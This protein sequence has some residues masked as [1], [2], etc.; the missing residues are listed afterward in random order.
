[1]SLNIITDA[2]IPVVLT[3]GTRGTIAPWQ[4]ADQAVL[5]PDWPRAD[6][7]IACLELLIGLVFLADPP[8]HEEDWQDRQAPDPDRLRAA[9][10]PFA[11]AFELLGDGPRFMQDLEPLAGEASPPD[12]L[13]IDSAGAN[14][15]RNNADLLVHRNRYSLID[16]ATAAMALHAFQAHA[17]S[18]G[19]GNRTS[20]RG[21]GP[22]VTLIDPG[23]GLW[24]LIW[25]NVPDGRPAQVSDLPWTR[26]ARSSEKGQEVWPQQACPAEAFFGMPRRLRLI[27]DGAGITGVVQRPYGTNY[28]G[29]VHPL[30]PY[31]R[32]K[33]GTELLPVHPRAGLFGYRNWLGV[34]A[35]SQDDPLRQRATIVSS[36]RARSGARAPA[37]L[38]V[39]GWSMDNMK[40]RDFVHAVVPLLDLSEDQTLQLAG[41]VQAAEKLSLALRA[42]LAPVVA[43]GE[44]RE[45]LR[46]EFFLRT[47]AP[48]EAH[49]VALATIP[50][51]EI[52]KSWL[53]DL[54][55]A[56]LDLFETRALP[57][58]ADRALSDQQ[59]IVTAHAALRGAF[60]GR[61]KLGREAWGLLGLTPTAAQ[62]KETA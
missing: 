22:L 35:A 10:E 58:L 34:V 43:E 42:A 53:D 18:G 5:R 19:K 37:R 59:K 20:M 2:W 49:V 12:M 41:M 51:E 8:A 44:T 27:A 31:Y 23:C 62:P 28:A 50:P 29:W 17:P 13:F 54:R 47:Q 52:A 57:G 11:P 15:V 14:T 25:A 33:P 7:N 16:L 9:L 4:C 6:L 39:A 24:S 40:P 32:M 60:A 21:G 45:A 1:M 26:P 55:A 30:T 56:A 48:F 61:T 36:W 38:R 3:D 46:E